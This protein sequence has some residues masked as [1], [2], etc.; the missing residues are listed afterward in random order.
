MGA[1]LNVAV[2]YIPI[3]FQ[4]IK[5][6]DAVQSGIRSIPLVLALVVASILA[7]ITVGRIGYYA[8]LMII[9]SVLTPIGMGLISTFTVST[10][11]GPWIGYQVL[12]GFGLGCGMQQSNMAAQTV[13]ARRDV[14]TGMALM[15]FGQSLGGAVFISV[16][17]NVLNGRLISNLQRLRLPGF[18]PRSVIYAGATDLRTLVPADELSGLLVAY[19]D[20]LVHAFYVGVALA[21]LSIVGAVAMEWKSVKKAKKEQVAAAESTGPG[22]PGAVSYTH[23]TLPT[24]RIV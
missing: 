18:D 14:A 3:W 13:L 6:V 21:A 24:K 12:L 8:P 20:A 19:N 1:T 16:A 9:S 4:A 17:Q 2:Y 11:H 22:G 10:G 7:G 15:F 5:G 23:L